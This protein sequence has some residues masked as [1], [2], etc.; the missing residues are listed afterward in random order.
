[1]ADQMLRCSLELTNFDIQYE[2]RKT[3]KA[4]ILT[5]FVAEI[6]QIASLTQ[7]ARKWTVFVD[8]AS[9]STRSRA[10]II[11]V[12]EERILVKVSLTFSS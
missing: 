6:I 12:N 3:L 7:G 5:D 4:Q 11:M 10:E 9:N 2:S 1:M 8:G